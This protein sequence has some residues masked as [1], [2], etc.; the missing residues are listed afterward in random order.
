MNSPRIEVN[1]YK[2][3]HNTQTLV[4]RLKTRGIAVSGVTK[5]VCGQPAIAQAMLNGGA[6]GLAEA[7]LS[8]VRTLR[9]AGVKS[10]ITLIRTP[11]MRQASEVVQLCEQ[12]YNTETIVIRA[13][14]AAAI[15]QDRNHGVILMV[16]MGDLREGILPDDLGAI[17]AN[18]V[19]MPGV[20]LTG[21]GANFACLNGVA[22]TVANMNDLSALAYDTEKRI[23]FVLQTVSGGNSANLR[24]A[25]EDNQTGRVND[26]RL[27][28]AILC[29]VD[30]VTG[31]RISGL[32]QDTFSIV[33]DVIETDTKPVIQIDTDQPIAMLRPVPRVD[34]NCRLILAIGHQDTD[35]RGLTMPTGYRLVGATSDHLV[36]SAEKSVHSVGSEVR[37]DINYS[38]LMR[39][40]AAPDVSTTFLHN[41]PAH[42]TQIPDAKHAMH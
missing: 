3:R 11:M 42:D 32:F 17:A 35:V 28:E 22:P 13:L 40:M 7:R 36:M 5:A 21:I 34:H 1:L 41:Q 10:A 9:N 2:I 4:D 20:T 30:P 24:W 16:E 12:S 39:A 27:G 8:N 26:L 19:K 38:A 18:V 33:A 25:F 14:A 29:G 31:D 23:G 15:Q 37:F 6:V